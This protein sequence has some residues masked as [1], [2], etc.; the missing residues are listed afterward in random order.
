[1][2]REI[3]MDRLRL[4]RELSFGAQV[5]EEETSELADYF[6]ET[7]QWLRIFGG[8]VDVIRGHKGAGK[9]AIYLLLST[10][11]DQLFDKG[12]LLVSAEKPRGTPVFKDLIT[13][14]PA[15]EAEFIGLWKL[16]IV[17]LI[18]QRMKEF[19]VKGAAAERL[20]QSLADQ[21][22]FD[23]DADLSRMFRM[24]KEYARRWLAPKA[25]EAQH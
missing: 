6:V 5:A 3:A 25:V 8:E 10:R 1:M 13:E 9:S 2:L 23:A 15:S 18:A 14:P 7:D 20:Y 21:G 16:Y 12:I 24:V 17:T 22:L 11:T 19:D 4:L